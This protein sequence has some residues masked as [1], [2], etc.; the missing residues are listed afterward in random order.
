MLGFG[1][2]KPI[3][4]EVLSPAALLSLRRQR[5][6]K[7]QQVFATEG[8]GLGLEGKAEAWRPL[9]ALHDSSMPLVELRPLQPLAFGRAARLD[10]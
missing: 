9:A 6:L 2:G 1:K 8:S 5:R 10:R 7:Q 3:S 4:I